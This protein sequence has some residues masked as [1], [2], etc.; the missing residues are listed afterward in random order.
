MAEGMGLEVVAEGVE[1]K[2]QCEF[3]VDAGCTQVQGFYFARP[4]PADE[5]EQRW[6]P[7]PLAVGVN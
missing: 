2:E 6:A 3:L 4:L 7:L 5:L 1:T